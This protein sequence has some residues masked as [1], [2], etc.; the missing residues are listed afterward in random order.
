MVGVWTHER[1]GRRL[2][3]RIDPFAGLAEGVCRAAGEEAERPA[4]F[5]GGALEVTWA[6]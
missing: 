2:T 1:K 5:L 6:A 4:A 3:V